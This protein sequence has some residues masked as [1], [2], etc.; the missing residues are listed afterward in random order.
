MKYALPWLSLMMVFVLTACSEP[1]PPSVNLYRAVHSGDLNQVERHMYW[2]TE[3]NRPD[4][5]GDFPLHVAARAGRV[6]IARAL[7]EHGADAQ[8]VNAAG[9]TVIETAL[10]NGKTQVAQ[11]LLKH[12]VQLDAQAVLV[13][14]VKAGVSDRDAFTLLL[15][16]GARPNL[17]DTQGNTLLHLAIARGHRDTVARLIALGADVNQPD[18]EQQPPLAVALEHVARGSA[19]ARDIVDLLERS[20]ARA[21]YQPPQP[22]GRSSQELG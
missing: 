19:N 6:T 2:K 9:K 1:E 18:G 21:Q 8:T 7:I 13:E 5:N 3:V 20:G 17:P 14:L 22:E 16:Q 12:G 15:R 10:A 4:P 11:M